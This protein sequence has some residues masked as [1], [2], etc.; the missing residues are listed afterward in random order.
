[1]GF[2]IRSLPWGKPRG[3]RHSVSECGRISEKLCIAK[4]PSRPKIGVAFFHRP[5]IRW[6]QYT[7]F[8]VCIQSC[9]FLAGGAI[10][11]RRIQRIWP[12]P[13][14]ISVGKLSVTDR[15]KNGVHILECG[16]Y[17]IKDKPGKVLIFAGLCL[18]CSRLSREKCSSTPFR[19]TSENFSPHML[20][21]CL[22]YVILPMKP[23]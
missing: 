10:Q 8:K 3:K 5:R 1:M 23:L 9:R 11:K 4:P 2:W 12:V 20:T 18:C 7:V 19:N 16:A 15:W 13:V 22:L 6:I 21:F 14:G 17:R